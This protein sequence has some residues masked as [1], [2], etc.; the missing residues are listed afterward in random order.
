MVVAGKSFRM[1]CG[2][3]SLFLS[4]LAMAGTGQGVVST[5]EVGPIYGSKVFFTVD[6]SVSGQPACRQ[7]GNYQFVFDSS[8][9]G[10]RDLLALLSVAKAT[11]QGVIVSGGGSCSLYGGVEDVRW[12]RIQ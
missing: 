4:G 8:V 1:V 6:G 3:L 5:L 9:P 11:R 10:G 12:L 7:E 2:S